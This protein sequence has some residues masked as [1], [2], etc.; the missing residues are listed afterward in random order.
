MGCKQDQEVLGVYRRIEGAGSVQEGSGRLGGTGSIHRRMGVWGSQE[1]RQH[2][3]GDAGVWKALAG[4]GELAG[5]MVALET[6]DQGLFL[7]PP[8]TQ[9]P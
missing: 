3:W 1:Y 7:A 2:L 9:Q 5:S 8:T 6:G 4:S